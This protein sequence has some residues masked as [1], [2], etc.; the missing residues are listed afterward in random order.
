MAK[1]TEMVEV[2]ISQL[3]PYER[4]AKQHPAEQIEKLKASIEEF[5]FISPCLIDRD[6]NIIAG[7]GRV[8][9]AKALGTLAVTVTKQFEG[10]RK[11]GKNHQNVLV[12]QDLRGTVRE[13]NMDDEAEL[14][15]QITETVEQT[16]AQFTPNHLK[17]LTFAKGD[18]K[19]RTAELGAVETETMETFEVDL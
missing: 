18:A 4:N 1:T 3:K 11:L 10:S 19:Q 12:F 16:E 2:S 14:A 17:M 13:Y 15:E 6:G 5:G 7:H 9:A 8:E